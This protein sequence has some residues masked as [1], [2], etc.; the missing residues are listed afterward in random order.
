[1]PDFTTMKK[2]TILC[3]CTLLLAS[4]NWKDKAKQAVNKTGEIAAR[5]GSELADGMAK[6]VEKTFQNEVT[7]T[8][9]LQQAGL[10]HGKILINSSD[11]GTDNIISAYLIFG[12]AFDRTVTV[13]VLD[14]QGLE[15]GR[16]SLQLKGLAGQARYEDFIFD[17]RTHIQSKSKLSFE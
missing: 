16:A 13:R 17:K 11:S 5:A 8:P 12:S 6:G 15:Y 2:F 9:A 14:E 1:M 7:I 3:C 4:C 10:S